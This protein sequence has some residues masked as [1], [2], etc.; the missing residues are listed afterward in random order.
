M[1]IFIVTPTVCTID[2]IRILKE[3]TPPPTKKKL[4]Q[5]KHAKFGL[6]HAIN[7]GKEMWIG[8]VGAKSDSGQ[9]GGAGDVLKSG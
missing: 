3:R 5:K 7:E 6:F 2:N 9:C 8:G 1:S 4:R